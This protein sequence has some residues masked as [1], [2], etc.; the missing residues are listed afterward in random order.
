MA[1]PEPVQRVE[2][3]SLIMPQIIK[4]MQRVPA[5]PAGGGSLSLPQ[6]RMLLILDLEGDTTMG[7]LARQAG[8]TMPTATSSINTLVRGRYVARARSS[9]DRRVVLVSLTARGHKVLQDLHRQRRERL[10]TIL[11]HLDPDDQFRL[12]AAFETIHELLRKMDQALRAAAP[13]PPR[14]KAGS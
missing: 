11:A 10:A 8:V 1:E 9:R 4:Y 3:L 6:L 14:P 5:S 12:V 7:D 2:R 13:A